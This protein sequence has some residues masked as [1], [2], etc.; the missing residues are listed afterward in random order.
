MKGVNE[1]TEGMGC[2]TWRCFRVDKLKIIKI[3]VTVSQVGRLLQDTAFLRTL[4]EGVD[5]EMT[6]FEPIEFAWEVGKIEGKYAK[7]IMKIQKGK[8]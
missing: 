4:N 7:Y 6:E 5:K 1:D 2:A 3:V 8:F